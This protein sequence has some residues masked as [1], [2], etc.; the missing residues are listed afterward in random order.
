MQT[1][2]FAR[3]GTDPG[4]FAPENLRRIR[5]ELARSPDF[6]T[7][8]P[9]HGYEF[10]APLDGRRNIDLQQWKSARHFC[11]VRRFWRGEADQIGQLVHKP[12]GDAHAF[13]AFDY[14]ISADE[15]ASGYRF[16]AHTFVPGEFVTIRGHDA[17]EYTFR[18]VTV[19]PFR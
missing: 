17:R 14:E 11:N 12:G 3:S 10:V 7:G 6:P 4:L 9:R 5:L 19:S 16:G 1:N 13:W 2:I 8:S 15:K 18:V